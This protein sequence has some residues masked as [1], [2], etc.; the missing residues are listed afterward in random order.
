MEKKARVIEFR[1]G[2]GELIFN[3]F[4]F[5]RQIVLKDEAGKGSDAPSTGKP[6]SKDEGPQGS[7]PGSNEDPMTD[8]QKR[9]LFRILAE[10]GKEGDEA[11][12]HLKD[13]LQVD[14]LKEVTKI[15]A[16][17]MIERLLEELK[18]GE[19]DDRAPF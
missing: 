16:S 11:H 5:D 14:S 10:Q 19:R 12:K 4:V 6:E 18:G 2:E 13:L 9:F 8:A 17:R 3:L 1:T 7:S 15:E